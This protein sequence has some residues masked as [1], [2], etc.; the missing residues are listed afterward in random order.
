MPLAG[1]LFDSNVFI[2]DVAVSASG[3]TLGAEIHATDGGGTPVDVSSLK[4]INASAPDSASIILGG[5]QILKGDLQQPN[6]FSYSLESVTEAAPMPADSTSSNSIAGT[7]RFG[8]VSFT[9]QGTY[10]YV[11]SP[12]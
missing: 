1:V 10:S 4:F 7:F 8:T 6:A 5:S 3:N 2:I 9:E 11:I 12:K